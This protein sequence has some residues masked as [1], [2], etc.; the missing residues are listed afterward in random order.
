MNKMEPKIILHHLAHCTGSEK[1]FFR[2]PLPNNPLFYTEGV[3]LMVE[4]CE[5]QWLLDLIFFSYHENAPRNSDRISTK[6]IRIKDFKFRFS[7]FNQ[8][9]LFYTQDIPFCTFPLDTITVLYHAAVLPHKGEQYPSHLLMLPS[10][11]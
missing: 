5:A 7:M 2:E 11:N 4:I 10:E 6:L 9:V 1:L 8:G 3:K